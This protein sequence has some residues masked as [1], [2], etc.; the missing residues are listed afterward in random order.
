MATT[1]GTNGGRSAA[2][3][4]TCGTCRARGTVPSPSADTLTVLKILTGETTPD[5]DALIRSAHA[6]KQ[7]HCQ[8]TPVL[9]RA[10]ITQD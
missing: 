7:P 9:A 1:N 2:L 8:G 10:A 5:V 4:W 6:A 3:E